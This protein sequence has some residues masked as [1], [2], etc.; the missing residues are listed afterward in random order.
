[1]FPDAL[2]L[3]ETIDVGAVAG[4]GFRVVEENLVKVRGIPR[5]LSS[6]L[7]EGSDDALDE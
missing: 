6:D 7:R 1:M 5:S 4:N 3:P 2:T